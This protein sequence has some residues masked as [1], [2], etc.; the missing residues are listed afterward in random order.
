[1]SINLVLLAEAFVVVS[2]KHS[3]ITHL[4]PL[5][6]KAI[7]LKKRRYWKDLKLIAL[8]LPPKNP[9]R[10]SFEK[11]ILEMDNAQIQRYWMTAHYQGRRPPYRVQSI[12]SMLLY[13]KKVEGSIGYIPASLLSKELKVL[14]RGQF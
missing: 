9:L 10:Q 2:D 12:E 11:H 4:T 5:E 13:L 1:M 6:V 8:N 7:Y 3:S 14:Y